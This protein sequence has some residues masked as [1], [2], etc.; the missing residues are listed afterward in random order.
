MKHAVKFQYEY[1]GSVCVEMNSE[2][3]YMLGIKSLEMTMLGII[4]LEKKKSNEST[5]VFIFHEFSLRNPKSSL[6]SALKL[7]IWIS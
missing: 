2:I 1:F 3:I 4:L 7:K 6:V 5:N